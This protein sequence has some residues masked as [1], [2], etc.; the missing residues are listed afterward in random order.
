MHEPDS[1]IVA[2]K[3]L[4]KNRATNQTEAECIFK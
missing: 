4:V 2:N 1:G 3:I